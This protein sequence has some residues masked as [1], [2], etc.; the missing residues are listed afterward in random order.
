M[1]QPENNSSNMQAS[2]TPKPADSERNILLREDELQHVLAMVPSED[3]VRMRTVSKLFNKTFTRIGYQL[4]PVFVHLYTILKVAGV[5]DASSTDKGFFG[6]ER[7]GWMPRAVQAAKKS[8]TDKG[9][10]E[11]A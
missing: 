8:S 3:R 9:S 1:S 5:V 2:K 4:D 10:V 11:D 7:D 6:G